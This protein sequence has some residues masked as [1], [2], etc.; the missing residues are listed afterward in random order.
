MSARVLDVINEFFLKNG[1]KSSQEGNYMLVKETGKITPY[2]LDRDKYIIYY[3]KKGTIG[4]FSE[5]NNRKI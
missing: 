3:N 5:R 4:S 1:Q 2:Y